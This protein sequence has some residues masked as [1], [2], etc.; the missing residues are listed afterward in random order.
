MLDFCN[1]MY[2]NAV[3]PDAEKHLAT[4]KEIQ[5]DLCID[6]SQ[7]NQACISLIFLAYSLFIFLPW[8]NSVI[9]NPCWNHWDVSNPALIRT[10][11][12]FCLIS[13]RTVLFPYQ[14]LIKSRPGHS[15]LLP[16]QNEVDTLWHCIH[17][18]PHLMEERAVSPPSLLHS[19]EVRMLISFVSCLDLAASF[20]LYS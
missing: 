15:S 13:R 8:V 14:H 6:I 2:Q 3:L 1:Q 20:L 11:V 10:K 18:S 16:S 4:L 9:L 12:I 19:L 17:C 5:S 7:S